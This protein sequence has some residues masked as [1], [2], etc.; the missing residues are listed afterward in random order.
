LPHA[1]MPYRHCTFVSLRLCTFYK[2]I[3]HGVDGVRTESHGFIVYIFCEICGKPEFTRSRSVFVFPLRHCAFAPLRH[4]AVFTH[5]HPLQGELPCLM[6]LC[7]IAIVPLCI[8]AFAPLHLCTIYKSINHGVDGV[9]TESH[10]FIVLYLLR[11]LRN[12]W[13]TLF[14]HNRHRVHQDGSRRYFFPVTDKAIGKKGRKYENS[15]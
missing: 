11:Y 15:I 12:L 14:P 7:H 10:G 4:Y 3:N 9:R 13:E 2:S 6:L 5:P 1:V 8:C